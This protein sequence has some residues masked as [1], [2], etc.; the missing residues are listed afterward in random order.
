MT[1]TINVIELFQII[2]NL[3]IN[4][5]NTAV[6]LMNSVNNVYKNITDIHYLYRSGEFN[7]EILKS[8]SE[9]EEFIEDTYVAIH[10]KNNILDRMFHR[11]QLE[12]KEDLTEL[13]EFINAMVVAE[14]VIKD[15]RVVIYTNALRKSLGSL[16][17]LASEDLMETLFNPVPDI[18]ELK[19]IDNAVK[20]LERIKK[21]FDEYKLDDSLVLL[22]N[23]EYIQL[24][25]I[26]SSMLTLD[27]EDIMEQNSALYLKL[28]SASLDLHLAL[29]NFDNDG[30]RELNYVKYINLSK[31]KQSNLLKLMSARELRNSGSNQ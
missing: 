1:D 6:E 13:K 7:V 26:V 11:F 29:N 4:E 9:L 16:S 28:F 5:S 30:E 27:G 12:D 3:K 15:V 2:K 8:L 17:Y 31:Y 22:T 20:D 14:E 10:H 21:Y 25:G 19:Q 23:S 24:N 18:I